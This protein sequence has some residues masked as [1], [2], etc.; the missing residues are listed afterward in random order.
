[1][2]FET[3]SDR[4]DLV[5][6]GGVDFNFDFPVYKS[7]DLIVLVDGIEQVNG[8]HYVVRIAGG[9]APFESLPDSSL[10]TTGLVRF[11]IA[12]AINAIINIIPKQEVMQRSQYISQPFPVKKIERD[13]DYAIFGLRAVW[14]RIKRTPAFHISSTLKNIEIETPVVGKSLG[15]GTGPKIIN[16]DAGPKGDK[17]D[18]GDTG[19]AGAGAAP[20]IR[21][22]GGPTVVAVPS[23]IEFDPASGFDVTNPSG[24][25]ARIT[26]TPPVA[27][28]VIPIGAILA[29]PLSVAPTGW[30]L[31]DGAEISRTEFAALFTLLG[32][33]YGVGDGSTTFNIPNLKGRVPVGMDD[34]QT[35]FDTLGETGG[36]KTHVLTTAQMPAHTHGLNMKVTSPLAATGGNPVIQPTGALESTSVGS[37]EAHPNLQPYIVLNY[38]IKT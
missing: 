37:G 7:S 19:D 16:V 27:P 26:H 38:I 22:V 15:W 11:V 3:E 31:L 6:G 29:W 14:E 1:M 20:T 21:E 4:V 30:L 13:F 18:K 2:S 36:S 9:G 25:I 32:T 23:V 33:T 17:G 8:I 34:T 10:P 24:T 35:E 12:P 5:A 28:V